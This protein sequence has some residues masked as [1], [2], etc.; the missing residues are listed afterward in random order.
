[1]KNILSHFTFALQDLKKL[2]ES[3]V[4]G[5]LVMAFYDSAYTLDN[6]MRADLVTCIVNHYYNSS[7]AMGINEFDCVA[8]KIAEFFPN[9]KRETYYIARSESQN[10]KS[11]GKLVDKYYNFKR[12]IKIMLGQN[13]VHDSDRK[14]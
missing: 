12:K 7:H 9:E 4:N 14:Q 1:L 13:S 6:A 8:K 5:Q 3:N 10:R 11:S 2:L